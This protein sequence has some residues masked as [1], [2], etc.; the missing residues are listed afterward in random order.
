MTSLSAFWTI[1]SKQTASRLEVWMSGQVPV[2]SPWTGR[3]AFG[4]G[5]RVGVAV[6]LVGAAVGRRAV[7]GG[8]AGGGSGRGRVT[9]YP[10]RAAAESGADG[11]GRDDRA[12][13]SSSTSVHGDSLA[14]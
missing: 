3:C 12:C 4:A 10:L 9:V 6:G 13:N 5:G 7:G 1:V 11:D 14:M 2:A 8:A